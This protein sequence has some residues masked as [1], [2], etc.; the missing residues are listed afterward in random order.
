MLSI[1]A[2]GRQVVDA[3]TGAAKRDERVVRPCPGEAVPRHRGVETTS[4]RRPVRCPTVLGI[5]WE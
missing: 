3:V 2:A 4:G 1:S 5:G